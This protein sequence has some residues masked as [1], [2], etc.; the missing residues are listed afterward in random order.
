MKQR[1]GVPGYQGDSMAMNLV[2]RDRMRAES[3]RG[4]EANHNGV[5]VFV[6][7]LSCEGDGDNSHN[8]TSPGKCL[9]PLC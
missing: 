9:M 6:W 8:S 4:T 5:C 3:T 7:F 1:K 2:K